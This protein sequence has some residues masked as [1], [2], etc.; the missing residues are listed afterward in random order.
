MKPVRFIGFSQ[1]LAADYAW[2]SSAGDNVCREGRAAE[3]Y[4]RIG[5]RPRNKA[6]SLTQQA[7]RDQDWETLMLLKDNYTHF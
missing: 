4:R 1:N 7:K 6:L 5:E 2:S 3:T